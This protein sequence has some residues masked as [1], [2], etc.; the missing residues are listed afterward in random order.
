MPLD[1]ARDGLIALQGQVIGVLAVHNAALAERMAQL[2]AANAELAE[3]LARL[4]RAVSRNQGTP[5]CL[6]RLMTCPAGLRRPRR[7]GSSPG[8][9]G[10]NGRESSPERRARTWPG[11][12]ARSARCRCSRKARAG[13]GGAWPLPQISGWPRR[14]RSSMSR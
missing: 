10:R 4:E 12:R 9:R 2:E 3:R 6:P 11:A 7:S 13:A 5:R 8:G 14:T 1:A